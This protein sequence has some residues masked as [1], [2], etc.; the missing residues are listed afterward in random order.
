MRPKKEPREAFAS[1][2]KKELMAELRNL[3]DETG[4]PITK[5]LDEAIELLLESRTVRDKNIRI[6]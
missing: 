4:I 6:K 2:L 5:L 3:S 1:T